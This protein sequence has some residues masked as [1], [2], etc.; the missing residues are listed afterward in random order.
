MIYTSKLNYSIK[1]KRISIMFQLCYNYLLWIMRSGIKSRHQ[2]EMIYATT[3]GDIEKQLIK[4]NNI[5]SIISNNGID[6]QNIYHCI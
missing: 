3:Q 6:F 1:D 5:Y 2:S 4:R